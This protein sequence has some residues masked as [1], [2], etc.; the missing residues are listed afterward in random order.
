MLQYVLKRVLIFIPTLVV[1][2]LLTFVL[3]QL[4]PGDPVEQ[5]LNQNPGSEGQGSQKLA[6]EQAYQELRHDLGLDLP[7]FYLTITNATSSDTLYKIPKRRHRESLERLSY[8]YGNWEDVQRYYLSLKEFENLVYFTD[9]TSENNKGL[10]RL[11]DKISE[12]YGEPNDER[13]QRILGSMNEVFTSTTSLQ[14]L[15]VKFKEVQ[16][17]YELMKEQANP[18]RKYIPSI[19]WYGFSNQYHNWFFGDKPWFFGEK[20]NYLSA[21]FLRGDFGISYQDRRPVSSILWDSIA[22]T[23][24]ISLLSILIAYSIAIPI[25]VFAA[26]KRGTKAEQAVSTTLFIL[27]SLPNFWIATMLIIYLCGGDYLDW[28]P[29]AVSLMYNP[30]N[31]GF[32]EVAGNTAFHLV[33]PMIV[34]T[35]GSLAFIS[36]QMRGGMLSVLN[37]DFV[38]TA[39]AKGLKDSKVVWKHALRNSLLPIIT[40]FAAVFPLAISGSFVI[41]YIFSIPGMGKVSFDALVARNYPVVFTVMMFTG[42]LTLVGTLVADLLYAVVDPRISYSGRK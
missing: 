42:I 34:W 18:Y 21:G 5:M 20:E 41:E 2:S 7:I 39:R 19:N 10:R 26:V 11:R 6:T 12:A 13:I 17:N 29:P 27:Y 38:R 31:A 16:A 30:P 40:L 28:F 14:N 37:Q 9:Q 33:L 35:Y 1:I 24:P 8:D 25:G 32:M 36:R 22:W 4:A 3:S 23:F 15:G